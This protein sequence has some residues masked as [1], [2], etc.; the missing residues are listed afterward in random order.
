MDAWTNAA[1]GPH[2]WRKRLL[3]RCRGADPVAAAVAHPIDAESLGAA[4]EA[5]A[6]GLIR[7]ILV[8]P[9]DKIAA[10]ARAVAPVRCGEAQILIKGAL[11]TDE[12]MHE[13]LR[14][15]TGL[16]TG[17]RLSHVYVM[18]VPRYPRPLLITDAAIAIAP[19]LEE[20]RDIVQNAI[21]LA[22]D[23]GI[24][25]AQVAVLS[26][27]ETVTSKLSSTLDA[28][29]LCKM[30]ERGQITGGILDGRLA[31]DNAVSP[32]AAAEMGLTSKVGGCAD[33][34][35]APDLV[36]G[37]MI[38]KQ[39]TFLAGA[40]GAGA[41]VGAKV[42]IVLTSRADP[43][44]TRIASVAVAALMALAAPRRALDLRP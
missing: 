38:A 30:A 24:V 18:D 33:V 26:A 21:D 8:G 2:G 3:E 44:P 9:G 10:A 15:E 12:L 35:V 27:V 41:V 28:A 39:L 43:R 19:S 31:F 17:R 6:L 16:R 20:K 40:E 32:G 22:H 14:P 34:L 29:A 4:L 11:H 23:L 13:V 42:P 5:A 7:P 1:P 36:S 25:E 37:N